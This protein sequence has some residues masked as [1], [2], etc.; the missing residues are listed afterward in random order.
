MGVP[1]RKLPCPGVSIQQQRVPISS[2]PR[3]VQV[4]SDHEERKK[5]KKKKK[6]K[7]VD[8]RASSAAVGC[9]QMMAEEPL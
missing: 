2:E 9:A 3:A 1:G 8:V 4:D 5:K 6:H 7:E